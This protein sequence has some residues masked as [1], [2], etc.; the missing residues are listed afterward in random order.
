[1]WYRRWYDK[2]TGFTSKH[3]HAL[4]H[5]VSSNQDVDRFWSYYTKQQVEFLDWQLGVTFYSIQAF[6]MAVVFGYVL[7]WNEGYLQSEQAIGAVVTHVAG[8]ALAVSTGKEA[9]RYF[10]TEELTYP[11]MEN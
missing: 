8:D 6:M 10:S 11:G 7:I 9:T 2:T 3:Y 1:M 5:A 4:L